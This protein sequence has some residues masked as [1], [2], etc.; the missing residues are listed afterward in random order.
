MNQSGWVIIE[1]E[2][3]GDTETLK[4]N[5]GHLYRITKGEAIAVAFVPDVDLQR[6]A[7]H[8]RDAYNAGFKDGSDKVNQGDLG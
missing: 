3:A 1:N 2:G 7:A 5:G 6:Y 4:V 8:L